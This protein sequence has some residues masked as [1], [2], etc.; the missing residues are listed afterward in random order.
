MRITGAAVKGPLA[1]ASICAYALAEGTRGGLLGNCVTTGA[2]G[3]YDLTVPG[4]A[5]ILLQATGGSYVDETTHALTSL[6]AGGT[7]TSVVTGASPAVN[8]YL[9]PLTTLAVNAARASGTLTL[10]S[11]RQQAV[12]LKSAFNLD[13]A[14]DLSATAPL[15]GA[16]MNAYGQ[17]LA[18]VSRLASGGLG[19][20]DF[21][22]A[23]DANAIA[24]AFI[25]A[26]NASGNTPT[27]P[28]APVTP[29]VPSS[30]A[31]APVASGSL[32]VSN[33][34]VA[35][36]APDAAGFKVSIDKADTIYRFEKQVSYTLGAGG[37]VVTGQAYLSVTR[38]SQG[39]G[40]PLQTTIVQASLA[41]ELGLSGLKTRVC[42][43]D[44]G[45]TL[46]TPANTSHP[47]TL[48]FS[49]FNLDGWTLDGSLTGEASGAAWSLLDLPRTTDGIVSVN[50]VPSMVTTGDVVRGTGPGGTS[51]SVTL[52]L[53]NGGMVVVADVL[54][55]QGVPTAPAG[56]TYL[57][58]DQTPHFCV[59]NCN[60]T[61]TENSTST[62]VAFN[63]SLLEG[64]I[65]LDNSIGLLKTQGSL[66]SPSLGGFSPVSDSI[67]SENDLRTL[68]F[69]VLGT[70]AQGGISLVSVKSR[71]GLVEEVAVVSG[72]G[73]GSYSC[74]KE[75]ADFIG[76][77]ACAG[78]TLSA[79]GRSVTFAG[80]SVG[81]GFG[82]NRQTAVIEGTLTARG[83]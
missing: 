77:P 15:F 3:S 59:T 75:A 25:Q 33:A 61:L 35:S 11:F 63:G 32:S 6:P 44:C 65:V 12:A 18:A 14:L 39:E 47:V 7:L 50:G 34:T 37:P 72:I 64:G 30:P 73:V 56:V 82:S 27:G 1:G 36:F 19:L 46:S 22:S 26:F 13:A 24:A 9:T 79:N 10:A 66:A 41:P 55:P 43:G 80:T 58:P 8:A 74:F 45:I 81:G 54:N 62:V 38:R 21:L 28:T 5:E 2:N 4:S 67:R 23:P 52:R 17:A 70:A 60:V 51:R 20:R 83:F 76:V 71:G 42:P 69:S 16:E 57:A 29:T 78:A 68:V 49:N 53:R 48:A 40:G 31:S